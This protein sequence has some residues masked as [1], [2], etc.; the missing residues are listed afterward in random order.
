MHKKKL[1]TFITDTTNCENNIVTNFVADIFYVGIYR[2]IIEKIRI[3]HNLVHEIV[4]R[5]HFTFS[6]NDVFEKLKFGLCQ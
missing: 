4:S 5:H 1:K 6:S 2:P 3:S